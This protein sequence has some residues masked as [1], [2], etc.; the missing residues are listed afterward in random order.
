MK[1]TLLNY[2]PGLG[3][4]SPVP[5]WDHNYVNVVSHKAIRSFCLDHADATN[6][7]DRWYRVVRKAKWIN[8]AEVK[9]TFNAADLV[10]PFT[11]F[12]I[13]GN[14]Y[15]LIAGI[16]INRGFIFIRHILTH[17]QYDKGAWK[18]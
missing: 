11:V 2:T 5:L 4:T 3:L 7:L 10:T 17:K 16:N 18:P 13:G 8:F 14:K 12:D 1:L 15:R 9:V 6:P